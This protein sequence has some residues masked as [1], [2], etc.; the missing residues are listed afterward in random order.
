MKRAQTFPNEEVRKKQTSE[1][2]TTKAGCDALVVS[3]SSYLCNTQT[4][5][6]VTRSHEGNNQFAANC[7][8]SNLVRHNENGTW[9]ILAGDKQHCLDNNTESDQMFKDLLCHIGA[10][11]L[12]FCRK[13]IY[14]CEMTEPHE[15]CGP[16]REHYN[17]PLRNP[18]DVLHLFRCSFHFVLGSGTT[19]F[20]PAAVSFTC[21]H[22]C[23]ITEMSV[24][25]YTAR[26]KE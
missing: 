12:T 14:C 2:K 11:H 16:E 21:L 5:I 24:R 15:E 4:S 22:G 6:M 19:G 17:D 8:S 20:F 10:F 13:R 7:S 3:L 1:L 18:V 9:R 23:D 25:C 26:S